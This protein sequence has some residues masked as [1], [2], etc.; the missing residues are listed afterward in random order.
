MINFFQVLKTKTSSM[1]KIY[2]NPGF[3]CSW[4]N[5]KL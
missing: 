4:H 3:N 1:S 2:W 5:L